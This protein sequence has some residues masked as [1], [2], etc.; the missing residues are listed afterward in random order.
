MMAQSA[1][2]SSTAQ[3]YRSLPLPTNS[4]SIRVLE[5]EPLSPHH[6]D[7]GALHADIRIIDLAATL[8]PDFTALS[9]VWGDI[10]DADS[11]STITL[12]AD[13]V[14]LQLTD[15]CHKALET[16]R[17]SISS[18]IIWVD[19]ICINQD[20]VVEKAHQLSL[21]GDVYSKADTTYIW[22]GPGD[23]ASTR[24]INCLSDVGLLDYF[25][26]TPQHIPGAHIKPR[27]LSAAWALYRR[28]WKHL[29]HGLKLQYDYDGLKCG[30]YQD[31][32][33][34]HAIETKPLMC[35]RRCV[36]TR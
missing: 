26:S 18:L 3:L 29:K 9:Y 8:A 22:L 12:G 33:C 4:R 34:S 5:I 36:Q 2:R 21:M 19:A 1:S 35:Y 15:N 16:L 30:Y 11:T 23:K 25:F 27:P 14:I 28:R 31:A 17:S 6:V 7:G 13:R 32:G 10:K 24:A 20:D